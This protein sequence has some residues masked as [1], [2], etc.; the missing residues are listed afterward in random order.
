MYNT[1]DVCFAKS[2]MKSCTKSIL[3]LITVINL[4][5]DSRT[6]YNKFMKQIGNQ[7]LRKQE[8]GQKTF[9][10][11][12][13]E[14]AEQFCQWKANREKELMQL[15]KE[16][17][18]NEYERHKLQALNQ[19]QKMVL[20][21]KTE[22]VVVATKRLKELLEARK[23]SARENSMSSK[24]NGVYG[25][26]NEK[27]LQRWFDHELEVMLNGGKRCFRL[28]MFTVRN[29]LFVHTLQIRIRI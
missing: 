8:Y 20:Q 14:E 10:L 4:Y 3:L 11:G 25:Q 29:N 9:F 23:S 26:G 19:H 28:Q 16:G 13:L 12:E 15:R 21:R 5:K 17:R 18:R 22:E 7:S 6:Y 2:L 1:D 24:K 27:S